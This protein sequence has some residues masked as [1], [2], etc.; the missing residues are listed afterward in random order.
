MD[1]QPI[2]KLTVIL[3]G[4]VLL[5]AVTAWFDQPGGPVRVVRGVVTGAALEPRDTGPSSQ[6]A[7]VMLPEGAKVRARVIAASPVN[8]GETVR[9]NEYSG[10]MTGRKTY[11][12]ISVE[13]RT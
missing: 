6:I 13:G 10:T 1:P 12:V 5:A 3:G 9:L 11:E 2:G 7:T 8:P 4:V